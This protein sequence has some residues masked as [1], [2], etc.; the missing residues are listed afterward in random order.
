[1][2]VQSIAAEYLMVITVCAPFS[3]YSLGF[4]IPLTDHGKKYEKHG[5]LRVNISLIKSMSD[6]AH[7]PTP[8]VT[9]M[10]PQVPQVPQH[11]IETV[12]IQAPLGSSN[13]VPHPPVIQKPLLSERPDIL[14]RGSYRRFHCPNSYGGLLLCFSYL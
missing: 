10:I 3:D 5:W 4:Q 13:C 14:R 1:M 2:N 7:H 11:Q 8:P 12:H 9:Y 6:Y